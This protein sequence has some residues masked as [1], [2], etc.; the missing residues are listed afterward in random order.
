MP[1]YLELYKLQ[2]TEAPY[3]VERII[4]TEQSTS[5]ECQLPDDLG[6]DLDLPEIPTLPDLECEFDIEVPLIPLPYACAPTVGGSISFSGCTGTDVGGSVSF[7]RDANSCDY[8]LGGSITICAEEP[9]CMEGI[10]ASGSVTVTGGSEWV[11]PSGTIT[12]DTSGPCGVTLSG[13][14]DVTDSVICGGAYDITTDVAMITGTVPIELFFDGEDAGLS[15]TP[16]YQLTKTGGDC[17]AEIKL[18]WGLTG[19]WVNVETL[20]VEVC[21]GATTS[22]KKFLIVTS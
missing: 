22:T 20:E 17:D 7:T 13:T 1:D 5:P 15:L 9:E 8:V 3:T 6:L 2:T 18:E 11:T 19:T 21:D 14:I 12:L 10:T 4:D 16:E